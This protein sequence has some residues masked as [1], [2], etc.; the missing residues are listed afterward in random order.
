MKF[1][2]VR[3][4][5]KLVRKSTSLSKH[6]IQLFFSLLRLWKQEN[7]VKVA[8][9]LPSWGST[10]Q[11][12]RLFNLDLHVGVVGDL[13]RHLR[14]NSIDLMRFSISSHNKLIPDR[15]S[16]S[17]PV[18]YIS[19]RNWERLDQNRI[20]L[21]QSRYKAF[22]KCFDGF[23]VTHTPSFTELYS[24]FGKPIL[25]I[26]STR[27]EAPYTNRPG[28]WERLNQVLIEGNENKQIQ[29]VANN[30]G[31]ADYLQYF[32]GLKVPIVP[33]LCDS[34]YR[35]TGGTDRKVFICKNQEL[36]REIQSKTA[37]QPLDSLGTPYSFRDLLDCHEILVIPQ[38][39]STMTLFELAT[40]GAPVW[41]PSKDLM[42]KLNLEYGVLKELTYANL[43]GIHVSSDQSSPVN[44]SSPSYYDWWLERADFYDEKIM[45]NV[46]TFNSLEDLSQGWSSTGDFY[47][48]LESKLEER[49]RDIQQNWD[50]IVARFASNII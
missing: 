19:N 49:N 46:L 25:C 18:R 6:G 16:V 47:L 11:K 38:N 44:W 48:S 22:L 37:F 17:D 8:R 1:E 50:S 23:I 7:R 31:D 10:S 15:P 24:R 39:I 33:S 4:A 29:I 36:S 9:Y 12:S 35:W 21:F 3:G 2:P 14:R 26:V 28:D 20:R 32:T 43:K 41:V 42:K 5:L 13:E 34:G 45:P 40:A 27:Y 30:R